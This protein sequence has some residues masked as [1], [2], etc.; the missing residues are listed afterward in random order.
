MIILD[1][2]IWIWWVDENPKLRLAW[3][4]LIAAN[5]DNGLGVCAI[6]C[7]EVAKLVE[8]DRIALSCPIE[9][10]MKDALDYPGVE[11]LELLPQIAIDSTQLPGQ[12]HHDP[13]DQI[14]VATAR[15]FDV[16][17]LTGDAKIIDYLNHQPPN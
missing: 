12:F 2:H 4:K 1:T 10:W 6:S 9:E 14:I 8:H 11:L 3:K 7:W 5:I 15:F 17:L 16:P 13:A